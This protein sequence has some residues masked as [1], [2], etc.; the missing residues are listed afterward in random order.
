MVKV[1]EV[2]TD[3]TQCKSC[4]FFGSVRD[5]PQ[6]CCKCF[7]ENGKIIV[8]KKARKSNCWCLDFVSNGKHFEMQ[9]FHVIG[10]YLTERYGTQVKLMPLVDNKKNAR[11]ND[12][13]DFTVL[14]ESDKLLR[15]YFSKFSTIEKEGFKSFKQVFEELINMETERQ[16]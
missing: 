5:F 7:D 13:T 9:P 15:R 16:K 8:S 4:K 14:I 3:K 11:I 2:M 12:E 10:K 6:W 1:M